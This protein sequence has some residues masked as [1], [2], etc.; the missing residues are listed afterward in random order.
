MFVFAYFNVAIAK[1]DEVP[2][3]QEYNKAVTEAESKATK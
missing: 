1:K 2:V 3:S